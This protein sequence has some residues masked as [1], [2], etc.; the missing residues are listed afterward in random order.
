MYK[1][2]LCIVCFFVFTSFVLSQEDID[3][4]KSEFQPNTDL[5]ITI[6]RFENSNITIDGVLDETVWQKAARVGNFTEIHPRDMVEPEVQTEV[7]MFY[8]DNNIYFAFICYD[9]DMSKLRATF[10]DRDKI[11]NDDF[12]G[13]FLNTYSDNKQAYE[14]LT[15]AYGIQ[16]DLMWTPD[17]EDASY[18]AIWES[19]AKVYD[20]RW[21]CE[22]A[23]PFK[24]I[25]FPDKDIQEWNIHLYRVRPRESREQ[26]FW[27]PLSQDDP[28]L[29]T[30][31]AKL[32]GMKNIKGGNN[33]EVLPYVLGSRNSY[34]ENDEDPNSDFIS[35]PF[36][37]EFGMSL[38]YGITSNLTADVTVNPD[39]SQVESDAGVI[40]VN[41][42]F[43][44]FYPEKRP[45]F[46][47]GQ[48]IFS[49]PINVVYTRVINNP[50]FATKLT[51]KVGKFDIGYMLAYDKQTPFIVPLEES[52][53]F[54][55]SDRRSLS[56]II[57]IKHSLKDDSYIGLIFTD[58][59]IKDT[60]S[61][62]FK[63][64]GYNRVFGLD[65]NY[66]FLDNYSLSFQLLGYDT[67]E[68]NDTTLYSREESD[69]ATF[70]NEKY[71]AAFDGE[72]FTGF[73]GIVA[74]QRNAKHWSGTVQY[75]NQSPV[76]R[77][78]NGFSNNNNFRTFFVYNQYAFYLNNNIFE[79][80]IPEL[81]LFVRHNYDGKLREVFME[82]H[83]S[84]Q[85]NNQINFETGYFLI[86]NEQYG[87]S[88][89]ENVNRLWIYVN[90]NTLSFLRGGFFFEGGKYIVRFEE[91][92]YVGYG[93]D[94]ELWLTFKPIDRIVM[95]NSYYYSQLGKFDYGGEKLY[96]G[97]IL[98]NKTTYQF[99]K[100]FFARLILQYNS[101]SK[102]IDI[103]PLISFKLNPFS[104][105][106]IGSTHQVSDIEDGP[107]TSKLV[108]SSRQI[109]LKF[110]YLWRM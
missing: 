44:L 103:D 21:T 63:T 64:D 101:F 23:I 20:D 66:R 59:E 36:K 94:F 102:Q 76:M 60:T 19:D 4:T 70:D 81:S 43:A 72:S 53:S 106:Y 10:S 15:N 37:G 110:Q 99:S 1:I 8:D 84:V 55:A 80:I 100:N 96:A 75:Y 7:L 16:G 17:G 86:N 57:R 47:E 49:T 61:S 79:R 22:F 39:F 18:D 38:K 104:I 105:F 68:V 14:I 46:L 24:S 6:S 54:I 56:N 48:S 11:F 28:S 31:S 2:V 65:G 33:L 29:F 69:Y 74:L 45:F 35:D 62:F 82:P 95:E 98:R 108:E 91:P 27:V 40:D 87:G 13:F 9:N 32:K 73:G 109:F 78:D 67:K 30:Q 52:S 50:I 26:H 83:L 93:F 97:Y 77:K 51:G 90:V 58:R 71:T 3:S 42:S 12:A 41:T 89:H 5:N 88:Y 34:L 107:R 85:F 25:R 92:S